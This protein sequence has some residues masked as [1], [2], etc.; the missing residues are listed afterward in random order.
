MIQSIIYNN[1]FRHMVKLIIHSN[2]YLVELEK[3][4]YNIYA[5]KMYSKNI[6]KIN[7]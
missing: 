6:I 2:I 5:K 4:T 1:T 7:K 3:G